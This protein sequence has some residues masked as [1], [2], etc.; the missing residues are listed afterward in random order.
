M[1][2]FWLVPTLGSLHCMLTLVRVCA[3]FNSSSERNQLCILRRLLRHVYVSLDGCI[4][5]A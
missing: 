4:V 5:V 2:W 1:Y 3:L